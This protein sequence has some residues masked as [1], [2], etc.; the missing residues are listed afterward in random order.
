ML[1]HN[2]LTGNGTL[3]YACNCSIQDFLAANCGMPFDKLTILQ[4][5]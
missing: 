5:L 3:M 4:R 2:C 1:L